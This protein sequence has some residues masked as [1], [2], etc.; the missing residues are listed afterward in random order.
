[1]KKPFAILLLCLCAGAFALGLLRLFQ[2]RYEA[3]DVYPPYSSLRADPLGTMALFESLQNLPGLNLQR[4]FS[5]ANRLPEPRQTAYLHLAARPRDWQWAPEPIASEIQNFVTSGGRLV[6]TFFPEPTK[7]LG[8]LSYSS[9]NAFGKTPLGKKPAPAPPGKSPNKRSATEPHFQEVQ[10]N[11]QLGFD[12]AFIKLSSGEGNSYEPARVLNR[13]ELPL[14]QAL[15]WHSGMVFTNLNASWRTIY[16]RGTD[17][18]AVERRLGSGTIVMASDSYFLSNEAMLKD[19][20]ADFLTWLLGP[21]RNVVFDEA[22]FG[23][24]EEPGVATLI[25]KYRLHSLAFGF[26]LLAGLFIWKNSVSFVPLDAETVELPYVSGRDAASGFVNLLRRNIPQREVLKVCFTEWTRSLSQAGIHSISRVDAAQ[27]IF[28][29]ESARPVLER[30]SVR[31]YRD[32][33]A[34]LKGRKVSA[35]IDKPSIPDPPKPTI[36]S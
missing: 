8:F 11:S 22:H 19:R 26:M 15:E 16:A 3:G 24:V 7:P 1:M 36:S 31:A 20:H 17:P 9:T 12:F 25:R 5:A 14:P 21:V 18:V 32:I 35:Q 23:V 10:L 28:E 29:A 34:V 30:S 4:D 33:C 27:T 2:L 13:T 6:V